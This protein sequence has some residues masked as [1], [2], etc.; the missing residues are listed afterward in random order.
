MIEAHVS[1]D[2]PIMP[3]QFSL[4]AIL[5][6]MIL[7]S[8]VVK[9]STGFAPTQTVRSQETV[10]LPTHHD[11]QA[12]GSWS[13]LSFGLGGQ[14]YP[15][16]VLDCLDLAL[17]LQFLA[18]CG[19]LRILQVLWRRRFS[20]QEEEMGDAGY[21]ERKASSMTKRGCFRGSTI[22]S[23]LGTFKNIPA[24]GDDGV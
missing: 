4:G 19:F 21:S 7:T 9:A 10:Q 6:S 1:G 16:A 14:R 23:Q 8:E 22:S 12:V 13:A 17:L 20:S 5:S 3:F 15:K 11:G 2:I 18:M 24:S